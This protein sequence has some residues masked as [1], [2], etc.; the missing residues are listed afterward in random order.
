MEGQRAKKSQDDAEKEPKS[1]N[2][3]ENAPAAHEDSRTAWS[4]FHQMTGT[5]TDSE[6]RGRRTTASPS[7]ANEISLFPSAFYK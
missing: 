2:R 1:R 7:R 6:T 3:R 4:L 5:R